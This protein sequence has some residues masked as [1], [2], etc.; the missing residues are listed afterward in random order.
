MK[1]LTTAFVTIAATLVLVGQ[2]YAADD[3]M[4]SDATQ[5]A[6]AVQALSVEDL[7]G[8]EVV[9]QNGEEIGTIRDVKIDIQSGRIQYVTVSRG[10]GFLGFGGRTFAAPLAVFQIDDQQAILMVDESRL[11]NAPRQADVSDENFESELQSHYG[12]APAW[13][14]N[15]Q[16][17]TD[18]D[19]TQS[20][21]PDQGEPA[22]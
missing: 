4:T 17:E 7:K 8:M 19:T 3:E 2:P 11:E 21:K 16:T 5:Q 1:T 13:R 18:S 9:S 15:I 10:G 14:Q 12:L 6:G 20:T 22:P